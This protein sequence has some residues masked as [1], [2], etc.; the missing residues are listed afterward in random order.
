MKALDTSMHAE[1]YRRIVGV[2]HEICTDTDLQYHFLGFSAG[3]HTPQKLSLHYWVS[4]GHFSQCVTFPQLNRGP[5]K[6]WA[7]LF[8]A[9]S[10]DGPFEGTLDCILPT[11]LSKRQ[12][13]KVAALRITE[14]V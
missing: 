12:I 1:R 3:D 4:N 6:S 5:I 14:G 2:V 13:A 9:E 11:M 7:K 8:S 10:R